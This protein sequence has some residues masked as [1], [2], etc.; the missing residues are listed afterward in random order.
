MEIFRFCYIKSELSDEEKT[1][2]N[3]LEP[4]VIIKSR[5]GR[6]IKQKQNLYME[7]ED[8]P[9]KSRVKKEIKI[10]KSVINQVDTLETDSV[11]FE[12]SHA[13]KKRKR[14]IVT[15]I[16]YQCCMCQQILET[17]SELISHIN[18]LHTIETKNNTERTYTSK[19][20]HV[21]KYCKIKFRLKRSVEEHVNNPT[22]EEPKKDRVKEY[23]NR[24]LKQASVGKK[25]QKVVCLY[26]GKIFANISHQKD[27][28]LRVHAESYPVS[29]PHPGCER[30]FAA[31]T[32]MRKHFRNHRERE[33]FCDVRAL[34][35]SKLTSNNKILFLQICGKAFLM[36]KHLI[37]HSYVHKDVKRYQCDHCPRT[38][39]YRTVLKQHIESHTKE[40]LFPC[41]QCEKTYKWYS[42]LQKHIKF[43]HLG[44]A[45]YK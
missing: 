34:N 8:E 21:C 17:E 26:C 29:C 1:E 14:K 28:E 37:S 9:K 20:R 12:N 23:Q 5:S 18:E 44:I 31:E 40:K 38:F 10:E 16:I 41:D 30:K 19:H 22:Y 39:T 25:D 35:Y 43:A 3:V 11:K 27:H 36:E 32:I 7:E 2:N 6:T 24:K 42:D 13:P 45:P 15:T 4:T 33:H